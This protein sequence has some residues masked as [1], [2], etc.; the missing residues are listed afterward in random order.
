MVEQRWKWESLVAETRKT[1]LKSMI[2]AIMLACLLVAAIYCFFEPQGG[3]TSVPLVFDEASHLSGESYS[4]LGGDWLNLEAVFSNGSVIAAN[5]LSAD[6]TQGVQM[7]REYSGEFNA[8]G[9]KAIVLSVTSVGA[10]LGNAA[11]T[12][13]ALVAFRRNRII[14]ATLR[15]EN[16]KT[17]DLGSSQALG[18]VKTIDAGRLD[19]NRQYYK[20]MLDQLQASLSVTGEFASSRGYWRIPDYVWRMNVDTLGSVLRG[21]GTVQIAFALDVNMDLKFGLFRTA[22]ENLT[23]A[24][25]LKWTGTWGTLE[26]IHEDG[27][28]TRVGYKFSFMALVMMSPEMV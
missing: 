15:D 19:S 9:L 17:T 18:F 22:G 28:I 6:S 21:S 16:T 14:T 13:R 23:G 5:L 10:D 26:L 11:S 4:L 7:L 8:T 2:A 25:N 24:T 12:M 20:A 1:L 3:L 27:E